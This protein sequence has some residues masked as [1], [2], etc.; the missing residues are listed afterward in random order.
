MVERCAGR[1]S[2][3]WK[4][5][6]FIAV[7]KLPPSHTQ[8][9]AVGIFWEIKDYLSTTRVSTDL[10]FRFHLFDPMGEATHIEWFAGRLRTE[11]KSVLVLAA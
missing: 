8:S 5:C 4:S 11:Q 3:P 2:S 9:P 7:D 1:F 6:A 10:R